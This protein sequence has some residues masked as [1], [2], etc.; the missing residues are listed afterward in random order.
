DL[1]RYDRF[2][3]RRG[4]T[5]P[6]PEDGGHRFVI[7]NACGTQAA[8]FLPSLMSHADALVP[9]LDMRDTPQ[10]DLAGYVDALGGKPEIVLGTVVVEA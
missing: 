8:D 10:E 4:S 7:V 6:M 3:A 9:I 5:R 1:L 2:R